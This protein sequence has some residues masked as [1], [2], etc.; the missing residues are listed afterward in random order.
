MSASL[1]TFHRGRERVKNGLRGFRFLA[2]LG[3]DGLGWHPTARL[4]L[5]IWMIAVTVLF[6]AQFLPE[7]D[8]GLD[9]IRSKLPIP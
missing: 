8:K 5:A 6:F 9:L 3:L 4:G 2:N 1:S 7:I